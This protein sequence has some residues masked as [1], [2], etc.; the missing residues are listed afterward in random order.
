MIRAW[1][2][3]LFGFAVPVLVASFA[4]NLAAEY[5]L[6]AWPD[7]LVVAVVVILGVLAWRFVRHPDK[8]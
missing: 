1:A 5:L 4:L 8:W 2:T 7:L 6:Q 3:N